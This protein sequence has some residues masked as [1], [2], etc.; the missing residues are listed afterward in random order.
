M[1]FTKIELE[2]IFAYE[3][4]VPFDFPEENGDRNIVLI[5]GR[6]GMG[7]TSFLRAI[8]LLFVGIRPEKSRTVG[9][10]PTVLPE[11]QF[12]AGDGARW[13][14]LINRQAAR[15]AARDG[16]TPTARVM[17]SWTTENGQSITVERRWILKPGSFDENAVI[18]VGGER[19]TGDV[20][21]DR[22]GDLMPSEFVDFFFFDGE[23][24]KELAESEARHQAEFDRLLRI[25]FITE[26][27]TELKVIGSERRRRDMGEKLLH[28]YTI[29]EAD[30]VKAKGDSKSA[31]QSIA[32]I[33]EALALDAVQL[34]RLNV[35]RENLSTGASE[36]QR[37][38]LEARRKQIGEDIQ[39]ITSRI[40]SK[41][42]PTAPVVA[43]LAL[44]RAALAA[45]QQR[46]QSFSAA[47]ERFL[48]R[49]AGRMPSWLAEEAA[50][51][52]Q[53][54][55][56]LAERLLDR[57]RGELP[58]GAGGPFASL[59]PLRAERLQAMLARWAAAGNDI[60]RA[61]ASELEALRRLQR[62]LQTAEEALMQIEVG[63]QAN[64]EQ[65][66]GVVRAIAEIEDQQS[67][68]AVR[69]GQQLE[70][71]KDAEARIAA[72]QAK[73]SVLSESQ[74]AAARERDEAKFISKVEFALNELGEALR[75]SIR[76]R[77]EERLNARFRELV[78]HPLVDRLTIDDVYTMTYFDAQ[79]REVGRSSL[80]SGLKQLAATALLWS[81]KDVSELDMPVIID[82]PLGRIDRENQDNMLHT[83]YPRLARQVIILP[84][85]SEIDRRRFDLIR[86]RVAEQFKI[87]NDS[88]DSARAERGGTLVQ[89]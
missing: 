69:K 76:V 59:D 73:L 55:E 58:R 56:N 43:N 60:H 66:K 20:A 35:R 81:L 63:S 9:F 64:L 89:A 39:E 48:A 25:T 19:L 49:I 85:N 28:D 79:G 62:E 72:L 46:V 50:L 33:E 27:A 75:R 80:S 29:V 21:K 70:K 26:L 41:V 61:Q 88:G 8:K 87:V 5:W 52:T 6:N 15:R 68:R 4:L 16:T 34:Q 83:Y 30:L 24:I 36:A 7:K 12:V 54:A 57:M 67:E 78:M 40:A 38:E 18:Y 31:Q 42:P 51:G 82:T 44:V 37:A 71:R 10:P 17:A 47:E 1:R 13:S 11:R 22:I 74:E 77:L 86:D 84:T 45:T 53:V 14:G 65:Y 3:G 32:G 23:D 2:N